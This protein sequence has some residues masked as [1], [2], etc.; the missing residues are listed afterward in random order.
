MNRKDLM[1]R[2][3]TNKNEHMILSNSVF[4]FVNRSEILQNISLISLVVLANIVINIE[5]F[6]IYIYI[7]IARERERE[8]ERERVR[9]TEWEWSEQIL[10]FAFH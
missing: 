1:R 8:R 6:T 5:I 10:I 4:C 9:Q 7:Y 3:T 2:K